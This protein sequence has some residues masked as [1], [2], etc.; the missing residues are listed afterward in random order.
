MGRLAQIRA[1]LG[2]GELRGLDQPVGERRDP[3]ATI[4]SAPVVIL[5]PDGDAT[6]FGPDL[7][8][9][10]W[11]TAHRPHLPRPTG[12]GSHYSTVAKWRD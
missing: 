1:R 8:A 6:A 11:A 9:R 2:P 10:T 5:P 12:F 7:R 3:S 4:R